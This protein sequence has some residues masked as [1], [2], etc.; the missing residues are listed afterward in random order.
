MILSRYIGEHSVIPTAF[1]L[2]AL[3]A[4]GPD[5]W[6]T[7]EGGTVTIV[8]ERGWPSCWA[9]AERTG[10]VAATRYHPRHG[11]SRTVADRPALG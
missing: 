6:S 9:R 8:F 11:T 3:V 7:D 1:T 4:A 5:V 10:D 2:D